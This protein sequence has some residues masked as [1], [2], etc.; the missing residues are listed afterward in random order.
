M[1]CYK[2]TKEMLYPTTQAFFYQGPTEFYLKLGDS[3]NK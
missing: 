1:E 3:L 2:N